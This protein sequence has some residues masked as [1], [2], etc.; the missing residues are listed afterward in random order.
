MGAETY[1]R[2]R[3]FTGHKPVSAPAPGPVK[4]ELPARLTRGQL[5]AA[6]KAADEALAGRLNTVQATPVAPVSETKPERKGGGRK[7][8]EG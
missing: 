1:A 8:K 3:D 7:R 5:Y 2:R 4:Q 6:R